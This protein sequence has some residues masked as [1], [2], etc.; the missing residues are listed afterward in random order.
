MKTLDK[1]FL[2]LYICTVKRRLSFLK[3]VVMQLVL[4][5]LLTLINITNIVMYADLLTPFNKK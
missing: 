5:G 1:G 3:D 4:L 2:M